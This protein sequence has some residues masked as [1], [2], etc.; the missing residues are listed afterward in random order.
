M[1]AS[2]TVRTALTITRK[3][4]LLP[5]W[6]TGLPPRWQGSGTASAKGLP[7]QSCTSILD[8]PS[9]STAIGDRAFSTMHGCTPLLN[10]TNANAPVTGRLGGARSIARL[11]THQAVAVTPAATPAAGAAQMSTTAAMAPAREQQAVPQ[12][13]MFF[14][15]AHVGITSQFKRDLSTAPQAEE[16]AIHAAAA[17]AAII[18]EEEAAEAAS[19]PAWSMFFHAAAPTQ[20]QTTLSQPETAFFLRPQ[21]RSMT[22]A[23]SRP[24]SAATD[25]NGLTVAEW[26]VNHNYGDNSG[27]NVSQH[28]LNQQRLD[29]LLMAGPDRAANA[30]N[31]NTEPA[32]GP[33]VADDT[34]TAAAELPPTLIAD[35]SD[36]QSQWAQFWHDPSWQPENK[37][38]QQQQQ[39]AQ[40]KTHSANPLETPPP[41]SSAA[42][43]TASSSIMLLL[44]GIIAGGSGSALGLASSAPIF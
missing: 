6:G 21:K 27:R 1:S 36:G 10:N 44:F 30:A 2:H 39:H 11:A 43:A 41:I 3:P 42:S 29:D 19:A 15:E 38:Q 34:T 22:T 4:V 35:A 13:S 28:S 20:Q 12:W 7:L 9:V 18:K 16:P 37:G 40:S 26:E 14:H 33:A 25:V 5:P 23:A 31:S 17:D 32:A 8:G 24:S